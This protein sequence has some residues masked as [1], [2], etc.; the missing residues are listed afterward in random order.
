MEQNVKRIFFKEGVNLPYFELQ[1]GVIKKPAAIEGELRWVSDEEMNIIKRVV[2]K[3]WYK[4][5]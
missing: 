2:V 3:P 1:N 5:W 4:L